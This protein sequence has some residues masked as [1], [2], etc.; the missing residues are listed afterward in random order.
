MK[1]LFLDLDGTLACFNVKNALERF[2]KEKDFFI[3]LKAYKGIEKVD[4][5]IKNNQNNIFIISASPHTTADKAK[6][7][8]IKKYLPSMKKQNIILCRLRRK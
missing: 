8:W 4:E 5:L 2:K 7:K 1:K 6:I 3:N